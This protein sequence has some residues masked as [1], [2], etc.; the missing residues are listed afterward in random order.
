VTKD[1]FD[2]LGEFY[3]K[4][5]TIT[6]RTVDRGAWVLDA[7]NETVHSLA[8]THDAYDGTY[9]A[10]YRAHVGAG[11]DATKP[12]IPYFASVTVVLE[13]SDD[14]TDGSDGTWVIR[15]SK[16]YTWDSNALEA[17]GEQYYEDEM[18]CTV[19]ALLVGD[20]IRLRVSSR[21]TMFGTT[22]AEILPNDHGLVDFYY[23][24]QTG[25]QNIA[26]M[27]PDA[28]DS[29]LYRALAVADEE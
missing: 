19:S 28:E 22:A 24:S 6:E 5:S 15:A 9:N 2:V 16:S 8:L 27:F 7:V 23:Y 12:H 10:R 11:Y 25:N 14:S 3:Q 1:G 26:S 21:N 29:C 13:T 4:T 20:F 17:A 18:S